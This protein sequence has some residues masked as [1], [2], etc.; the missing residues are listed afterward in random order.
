MDNSTQ[1]TETTTTKNAPV[2]TT[3]EM[4]RLKER[5]EKL[6]INW[7]DEHEAEIKRLGE[8]IAVIAIKLTSL[9]LPKSSTE[10]LFAD[11]MASWT[12]SFNFRWN[13]DKNNLKEMAKIPL[14]IMRAFREEYTHV[15]NDRGAQTSLFDGEAPRELTKAQKKAWSNY[16]NLAPDARRLWLLTT[17]SFLN[18]VH[19]NIEDMLSKTPQRELRTKTRIDTPICDLF[20]KMLSTPTR[21]GIRNA[22]SSVAGC[23][24]Y[25]QSAG[26]DVRS[27]G[28]WGIRQGRFFIAGEGRAAEEQD[29][30]ELVKT[31][32]IKADDTVLMAAFYSFC[33]NRYEET[34][35]S[36][37]VTVYAPDFMRYIGALPKDKTRQKNPGHAHGANALRIKD[38]AERAAS[39][40]NL[41]GVL[42][43]KGIYAAFLF[44]EHDKEKNTIT[45]E[46]PYFDR[47]IEDARRQR[48]ALEEKAKEAKKAKKKVPLVLPE[49]A[50]LVDP[51]I[52][53][54]RNT[55]AVV[56]VFN[57]VR[58]IETAGPNNTPHITYKNLIK[59]NP[60]LSKRIEE[61]ANPAVL[62]KRVFVKTWEYLEK[63]TT[64]KE[65][66]P[67]I[68][69][70]NKSTYPTMRTLN[71][72]VSFPHASEE[73]SGKCDDHN[74]SHRGKSRSVA[75][76]NSK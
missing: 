5:I 46:S 7:T 34:G 38:F 3:L 12:P 72:V 24:A 14:A 13:D 39:L 60:D 32:K 19:K 21:E 63:Y 29:L 75:K 10:K 40:N 28:E 18:L 58:L 27:I 43:G 45:F 26:K 49:N 70:P 52:V 73:M 55:V 65:K 62:L 50:Y 69:F 68:V 64:L 9:G 71:D 59:Q 47:L 51:S 56:N 17:A 76:K 11:E 2:I 67:T 30:E 66:Y 20:P 42:P 44:K 22:L 36:G 35:E 1:Q 37:E 15:L 57:I 4:R 41:I 25:L 23:G 53:T 54:A 33:W 31:G 48:L 74:T 61:S 6:N 16:Y 8:Q